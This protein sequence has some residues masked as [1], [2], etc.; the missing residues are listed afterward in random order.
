MIY[1]CTY[2][3]TH[4]PDASYM[5][6]IFQHLL[7]TLLLFTLGPKYNVAEAVLEPIS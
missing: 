5:E 7:F 6:Y 2:T 3:H 1:V 4:T